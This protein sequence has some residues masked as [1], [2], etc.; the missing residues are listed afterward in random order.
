MENISTAAELKEAIQL[1]EAEKSVHLQEMRENFSLTWENFQPANL[2]KNSMKEIGSSPF[3][4]NNI[5]NVALGLFAGYLSKRA[6]MFGRSNNKSGKFLGFVLQLGITNLVVY[7]PGAIK[8]FVR[9]IFSK[10]KKE[11]QSD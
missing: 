4:F 11:P 8:S 1:L 6:L 3:L 9:N 2:I 10:R 5:F 7:A